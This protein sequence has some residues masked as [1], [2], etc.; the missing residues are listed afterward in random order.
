[1][2]LRSARD[3]T[4]EARFVGRC[5]LRLRELDPEAR[6]GVLARSH[7]RLQTIS[8]GLD[9]LG[10]DHLT[11]EQFE[12]FRR[13]EVKDAVARLRVLVNPFDSFSV[14]RLLE[15]PASGVGRG[16]LDRL[17][18][19]GFGAGLRLV[20][21]LRETTHEEGDPF[22]RLLRAYHE[23]RIVV[24]DVETTGLDT[25]EDEVVELAARRVGAGGDHEE[26]HRYLKPTR[27][28]GES[29]AVHG[30]S[31]AFLAERGEDAAEVLAAFRDFA[32]GRVLVGHNVRFDVAMV[33]HH[34][35]RLGVT[36][37]PP[38]F[39]DTLDLARRFVEGVERHD[40][41]T[42]ARSLDLPVTPTH[43]ASDDVGATVGLLRVLVPLAAEEIEVRRAVIA[44]SGEPFLPIARA[45]ESWRR[46][47]E[48]ERPAALLSVVLEESGLRA[49]YARDRRRVANL[50]EL[51]RFFAR[52][53]R[54]ELDPRA[55]LEEL[56]STTA[57]VKNVEFLD[58]DD[59]R[60]PVVTVHQSKG[61]EFDAVF[62]A[63]LNEGEF[64]TSMSERDGRLEEERRLFYVALTRA[65]RRL[66]LTSSG[67]GRESRFLTA[68]RG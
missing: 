33:R 35:R 68:L 57:L 38:P 11:V 62:V 54:P 31:D 58:R 9:A 20:D 46:R 63:G 17:A 40:L 32:A 23:D 10:V 45:V 25:G 43:R 67:G 65:R 39:D 1:T 36:F 52:F 66:I 53:D 27:A 2:V 42:L 55:A 5:I 60:V 18:R 47:A 19:E 59:P 30:H 14:R 56:T 41:G 16:T 29:E 3:E 61:L 44:R 26:F 49:H 15:R 24:F 4:D 37:E 22:G 21:L 13:Q 8:R 12:F 34:A 48:E 64:P 7:R 6:V 50:E 28:V 51:V